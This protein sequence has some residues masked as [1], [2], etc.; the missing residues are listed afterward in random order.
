MNNLFENG[1]GKLF[2]SVYTRLMR[3]QIIL[4]KID[5]C[6]IQV[7]YIRA[8]FHFTIILLQNIR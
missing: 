4:V 3:R 2:I 7:L 8:V 6:P 5:M 1:S